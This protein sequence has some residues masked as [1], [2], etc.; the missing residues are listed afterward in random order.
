MY[1]LNTKVCIDRGSTIPDD[2]T[3]A[4]FDE[5]RS[6]G[7][8]LNLDTNTLAVLTIGPGMTKDKLMQAA[9][10][11]RKLGRNQRIVLMVTNEIIS[12]LLELFSEEEK[13][14]F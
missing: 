13:N 8:D 2:K 3:F 4:I 11:L 12:L 14:K 7:A 5:A 6:R 9:G 1:D 10:R